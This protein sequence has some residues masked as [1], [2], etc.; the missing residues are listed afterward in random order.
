MWRGSTAGT[1]RA[2]RR[3]TAWGAGASNMGCPP[4]NRLQAPE[5]GLDQRFLVQVRYARPST[6][7][8]PPRVRMTRRMRYRPRGLPL[9]RT[10]TAERRPPRTFWRLPLTTTVTRRTRV[11]LTPRRCTRIERRLAHARAELA[12]GMRTALG[13]DA[14]PTASAPV[15]SIWRDDCPT[16]T[17]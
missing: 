14:P 16:I 2:S 4:V 12:S 5:V 15:C 1:L 13:Q 9:S 8:R 17:R 6:T 7:L 11:R 3:P 10:R